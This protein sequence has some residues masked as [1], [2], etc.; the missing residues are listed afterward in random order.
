[1]ESRVNYGLVGLFVLFLGAAAIFIPLWLSSN[2]GNVKYVKYTVF[3]N[4]AVDGLSPNAPVKYNG[5]DVGH[6][7]KIQLNLKNTQQVELLLLI[8]EGTPITTHT[9]A[10]LRSQGVTGVA[11]IGLNGGKSDGAQPLTT[12]PGNHYPIIPSTPSTMVRIDTAVTQLLANMNSLSTQLSNA[13]SPENQLLLKQ[14]LRNFNQIGSQRLPET[15]TQLQGVLSNLQGITQ[16]VKRN[17]SVLVRGKA[18]VT[19]GP[20]EK[21]SQ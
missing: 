14:T 8:K 11:Y 12:L 5:V 3:M 1:M 7:T 18:S 19:L 9:T 2:L 4:E 10:T 15:L 6:V 17:P 13:L 21:A 20:G 16:E